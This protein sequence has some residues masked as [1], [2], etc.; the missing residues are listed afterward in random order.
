VALPKRIHDPFTALAFHALDTD[1]MFLSGM[2][3]F[4]GESQDKT[5]AMESLNPEAS[6][7]CF[8]LDT[9]DARVDMLERK[10]RD[11]FEVKSGYKDP[12][13]QSRLLEKHF[14]VFDSDVSGTVDFDEFSRAM[15]QLNFVGV[16]AEI[17]ALFDRFDEDLNGVVSYAEFARGVLGKANVSEQTSA[18]KAKSLLARVRERILEAGGK[19]GLRTLNVLLRRMDQNDNNAIEMDE[20]EMGLKD[21]GV[22]LGRTG[23]SS[24]NSVDRE[25][26]ARVFDLFDRDRSGKITVDE[27]MRGLRVLLHVYMN[28][29]GYRL[30]D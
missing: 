21:L 19:N 24:S 26:L 25:Q 17:E 20:F 7:S 11:L 30:Q 27:L 16:Q 12:A 29:V 22:E 3:I 18:A 23:S 4:I 6:T 10:L 1:M 15:V 9:M 8:P 13:A 2:R 14:R 28:Q 5:I